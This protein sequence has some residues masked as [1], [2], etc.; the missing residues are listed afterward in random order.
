MADL[1]LDAG[2]QLSV[3]R[4]YR[5]AL[6]RIWDATLPPLMFIGLNPSTADEQ[7]DDPTIR[8]CKGFA[9]RN[10]CGG[11]YMLNLF[12]YRATDPHTLFDVYYRKQFTG[13]G[14]ETCWHNGDPV[15]PDN[16]R[17]LLETVAVAAIVVAAWGVHGVMMLRDQAV[18]RLLA[19]AD[20]RCLGTTKDGHPRH[21]LYVPYSQPLEK[22]QGDHP[23]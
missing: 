14:G 11:V 3:C 10:G 17:H 18:K 7:K 6:W 4:T 13:P 20:L 5:Y 8:K 19:G 21:P 12:A 22:F 23:L 1:F 2:A 9:E 15:G 16:D